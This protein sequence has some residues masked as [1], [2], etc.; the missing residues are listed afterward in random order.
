[1]VRVGGLAGHPEGG[2]R[3]LSDSRR[4]GP[5]PAP[6]LGESHEATMTFRSTAVPIGF[7]PS[8]SCVR[9]LLKPPALRTPY[10][11]LPRGR[12]SASDQDDLYE[13]LR[14]QRT[15]RDALPKMHEQRTTAEGEGS[16]EGVGLRAARARGGRKFSRN[17]SPG[18]GRAPPAA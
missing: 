12:A 5:H 15:P 6:L 17:H 1:M 13:V 9:S 4:R 7:P 2:R 16:A 11:P 8:V 14:A 3:V 10:G 18:G